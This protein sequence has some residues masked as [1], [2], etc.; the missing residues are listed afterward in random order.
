MKLIGSLF[1]VAAVRVLSEEILPLSNPPIAN[2]VSGVQSLFS[3]SV[4][5]PQLAGGIPLVFQSGK[6]II[7]EGKEVGI[8]QLIML[9]DGDMVASANT[10]FAESGLNT[11]VEYLNKEFAYRMEGKSG[12]RF[13]QS[14]VVVEFEKQ[15][16][17]MLPAIASIQELLSRFH[18]AD[19]FELLRIS[20]SQGTGGM[21]NVQSPN[22]LDGIEKSD[23]TIE[24]RAGSP[25]SENRFF[26]TA[27]LRTNDHIRILE[28][29]ENALSR[30]KRAT[31]MFKSG[32]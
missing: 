17:Q 13:Y 5:P 3:F 29:I 21:P 15:L 30:L 10:D 24:R 18:G 22:P 32:H 8:H 12:K 23:F 28:E 19:P 27:P 11:L 14:V 2:I 4:R 26:C 7:S 6:I 1:G 20:F 9:P 25:F 31:R 16:S